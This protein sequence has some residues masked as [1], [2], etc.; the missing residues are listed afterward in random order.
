V[1]LTIADLGELPMAAAVFDNEDTVIASTPEW[2]GF[3]AAAVSYPVRNTRL[4]VAAGEPAPECEILLGRL[5]DAMTAASHAVG[6]QQ[7]LRVAMLA[8]SLRLVAGR[9]LDTSGTSDDVI[10]LARAGIAARASLEVS[11]ETGP[12]F[13]VQAPE[14]AALV[15][16]QLAVNAERHAGV[17]AVTITGAKHAFHVLWRGRSGTPE[18]VTSRRRELRRRWGMGFARIAADSL[19]GAVYPPFD[20]EDSIVDATLELGLNRLALPLAAVRGHR[21]LKATRAWDEET[22][23]VPGQQVRPGSHLA[24]CVDAAVEA[25]GRIAIIEGWSA[26]AGADHIWIS[27]PPDDV[28]DR[29]RDVLDGVVHERALWEGVPEP[30]QSR[31]FALASL[32]GAT[33]GMPLPRVPA[34]VWNRRITSL[35]Q[36]FRLTI[37]VPHFD[38]LGAVDPR[39]VACVAAALGEAFTLD[40][41]DLRLQVRMDSVSD[42]MLLAF[43][44]PA[45]GSIRLS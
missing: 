43:S 45:P 21:V 14:A 37:P 25:A 16:V 41:D 40:G 8:A 23:Q 1:N 15:L 30:A 34:A 36:A 31:V 42:P 24:A 17:N 26:R 6:D 11:I 10:S 38:G 12:A 32:L 5:L 28:V 29:A 18:I 2:S 22:G 20:R 33:L 13:R 4:V 7:R 39:I 9:H 35:A 19:G 44:Q 27:I 3:S